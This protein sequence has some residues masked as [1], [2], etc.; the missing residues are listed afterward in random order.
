M[1][2]RCADGGGNM[3]STTTAQTAGIKSADVH[4]R[5][6]A[7]PLLSCRSAIAWLLYG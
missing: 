6:A 5:L 3:E 7:H 1:G 2:G 4:D